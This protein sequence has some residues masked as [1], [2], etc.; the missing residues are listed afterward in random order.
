MIKLSA[1]ELY[2]LFVNRKDVYAIQIPNGA[3][4]LQKDE[5]TLSHIEKHLKGDISLG[6]YCL[7]TNSN[8]KWACVDLDGTDLNLLDYESRI[9]LDLFPEFA[10]IREF[11]G[12]RGYHVWVFFDK[13]TPAEYAQKLVKARLNKYPT[14]TKYEVFPKQTELNAGRLYGNLVKLPQALHR[15]SKKRSKILEME[16]FE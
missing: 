2:D 14:L 16:G 11:S 12:R 13:E 10:R 1:Q 4:I 5:L 7:D 6:I 9:I 8:V 15:V 3:Y